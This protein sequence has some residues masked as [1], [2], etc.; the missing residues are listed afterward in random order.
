MTE[1]LKPCPCVVCAL[2]D[3]DASFGYPHIVNDNP[4]GKGLFRVECSVL[5][6]GVCGPYATSQKEAVR[7]W[8][9]LMHGTYA[10]TWARRKK[11][12]RKADED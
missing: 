2:T 7:R 5:G 3:T 4:G 10:E 11:N 1:K 8:F 9:F 12:R 6:C